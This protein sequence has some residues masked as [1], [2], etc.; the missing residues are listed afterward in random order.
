MS[1]N[2]LLLQ[3]IIVIKETPSTYSF[4]NTWEL[5]WQAGCY[6]EKYFYKSD[7]NISQIEKA[8]ETVLSRGAYTEKLWAYISQR[9]QE[10][11]RASDSI[12]K[13]LIDEVRT[14][15]WLKEVTL[16][17]R[18]NILSEINEEINSFNS[19]D[20]SICFDE[21]DLEKVS[22][23]INVD[24][25]I[26]QQIEWLKQLRWLSTNLDK[27]NKME[28]EKKI[29]EKSS[30]IKSLK[31]VAKVTL[32]TAILL[33]FWLGSMNEALAR[34][35]SSSHSSSS[36]S[37]SSSSSR[38]YSS[39]SSSSSSYS[40]SRGSSS[41]R[42][43]WGGS[44]SSSN[45][46]FVPIVVTPDWSSKTL[47]STDH[48]ITSNDF[49]VSQSSRVDTNWK[50]FIVK[51]DIVWIRAETVKKWDSWYTHFS[52]NNIYKYWQSVNSVSQKY[53]VVGTFWEAMTISW[54]SVSSYDNVYIK[55]VNWQEYKL[56]QVSSPTSITS[57]QKVLKDSQSIAPISLSLTD[58]EA[59]ISVWLKN[60][61]A[62][63]YSKTY[64]TDKV[65]NSTYD[66]STNTLST[67]V[68]RTLHTDTYSLWTVGWGTDTKELNINV[69]WSSAMI[70]WK[71]LKVWENIKVTVNG[72][73]TNYSIVNHM[74]DAT[75]NMIYM[76]ILWI[77]AIS[78]LT[79]LIGVIAPMV[80]YFILKRK[81]DSLLPETY[82]AKEIW[83]KLREMRDLELSDT[84]IS[85]ID[86]VESTIDSIKKSKVL[87]TSNEKVDKTEVE[88]ITKEVLK[89][90][91]T[92]S[93]TK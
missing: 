45:T 34:S 20:L 84:Q 21:L 66:S 32:A 38:S 92:E 83:S 73:T 8:L 28:K 77:L 51:W 30:L 25:C 6:L 87:S 48:T 59:W 69:N 26:K 76:T 31:W 2:K 14:E 85:I 56:V 10:W 50:W 1:K 82:E 89:S 5:Y 35:S 61:S 52:Q 9:P 79:V 67:N 3:N 86:K 24:T 75:K 93:V 43:Y 15:L 39:S 60:V 19:T 47:D 11:V 54:N 88:D 40:N 17:D 27:I 46:V 42:S 13:N 16:N 33:W 81:K 18:V 53:Y 78:G 41:S 36:S 4:Y 62:I 91:W 44:S 68:E 63:S 37:H 70:N 64:D 74:T 12:I 71:S 80:N 57:V 72:K 29:K 23:N 58:S 65:I 22:K 49:I 7:I 90:M 55:L